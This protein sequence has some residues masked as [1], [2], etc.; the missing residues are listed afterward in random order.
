MILKKDDKLF[1]LYWLDGKREVIVGKDIANA[2]ARAGYGGGAPAALD[3]YDTGVTDT[4]AYSHAEKTWII[5]PKRVRCS[6]LEALTPE[7]IAL[8]LSK[9]LGLDFELPNKN[10]ICIDVS[11][12][13]YSA[14]SWVKQLH[15][16]EFRTGCVR[17][18][19]VYTADYC[20]G[21]YSD[22]GDEECHYL[23]SGSSWFDPKDI[24]QAIFHFQQTIKAHVGRD[25]GSM[26]LEA[27]RTFLTSPA[28]GATSIQELLE[29]QPIHEL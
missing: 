15:G 26:S 13:E 11:I 23:V 5:R 3:W 24:D 9:A 16:E 18:I 17:S 2:F 1:T 6:D 7:S 27:Y 12:G 28:A 14:T 20:E 19:R 25:R 10:Q 4:H 21:P 8:E 29:T 22:D